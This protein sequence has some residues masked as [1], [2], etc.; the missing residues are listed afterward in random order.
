MGKYDA[1]IIIFACHLALSPAY[2]DKL[3]KLFGAKVRG[4]TK[5]IAYTLYADGRGRRIINRT[6]G[7]DEG[8]AAKNKNSPGYSTFRK[9]I[10]FAVP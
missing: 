10:D 3:S 5:A 1:Q 2:I 6:Y 7:F 8:N 4:F 9:M